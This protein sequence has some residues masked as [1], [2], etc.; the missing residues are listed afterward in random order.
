MKK[1]L[2]ILLVGSLFACNRGDDA[3][4]PIAE[5]DLARSGLE[6]AHRAY[7]AGEPRVMTRELLAVLKDPELDDVARANALDL[8]DRAFAEG[9][10]RLDAGFE[11]PA[12]MTWMRLVFQHAEND[13]VR[14]HLAILNGGLAPGVEVS[15]LR[16]VRARDARVLASKTDAIGYFESGGERGERY[17]YIHAGASPAPMESG[18]YRIEWTYADGRSGNADVIVPRV[19]LDALP[20]L[21][22]PGRGDAVASLQP[23]IRWRAPRW[24]GDKT[25]GRILLEARVTPSGQGSK[26][27]WSMWEWGA[28][29]SEVAVGEVGAPEEA[30]LEDGASYDVA[31]Q[32]Q[33]RLAYGDLQLGG[34]TRRA[35]AFWVDAGGKP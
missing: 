8:V 18:A 21:V 10:G 30:S 23:T 7:T 9:K 14:S 1:A 24:I 33:W 32:Y 6:R 31:V 16:L 28:E 34:A 12:G 4:T 2:I 35:H 29:R 26:A 17:F 5:P 11:T 13:G 22:E 27:S 15:A 25:F 20:E 19:H 3:L